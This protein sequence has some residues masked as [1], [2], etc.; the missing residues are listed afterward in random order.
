MAFTLLFVLVNWPVL[1]L[2]ILGI[3][4]VIQHCEKH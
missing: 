1:F 3:F 2:V 4:A